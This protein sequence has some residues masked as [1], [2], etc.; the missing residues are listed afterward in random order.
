MTCT[1]CE[2]ELHGCNYH[3]ARLHAILR[4]HVM[5]KHGA[6]IESRLQKPPESS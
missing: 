4:D 1:T 5:E 6:E 2:H 3:Q